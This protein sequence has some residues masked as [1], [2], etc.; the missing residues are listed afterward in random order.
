MEVDGNEGEFEGDEN[1]DYEYIDINSLPND[2]QQYFLQDDLNGGVGSCGSQ[3][4]F[5]HQN[6]V[7][8]NESQALRAYEEGGDDQEVESDYCDDLVDIYSY[9]GDEGDILRYKGIHLMDKGYSQQN[10]APEEEEAQAEKYQCPETGSHF[11][12]LD[13]CKRVKKLQSRRTIID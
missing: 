4:T 11:E 5:E 8:F 6:N 3:E 2:Q 13:M 7:K 1:E 10:L 9:N 12:H